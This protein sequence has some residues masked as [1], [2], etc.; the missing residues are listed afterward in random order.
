MVPLF[1]RIGASSFGGWAAAAVL[2]E[3]ELVRKRKLLSHEQMQGAVGYAQMLPGATQ[4]SL[5]AHVGYR[6]RGLR[7]AFVA[8]MSY[9]AVPMTMIAIFTVLYFRF[10]HKS[11]DLMGQLDGVIAALVGVILAN[12][13]RIGSRYASKLWL[14]SLVGVAL[15]VRLQFKIDPLVILMTYALSALLVAIVVLPMRRSRMGASVVVE[16]A[17]ATEKGTSDG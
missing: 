8:T 2:M 15:F 9:L 16:P 10:L 11:P 1:M 4:V 5:V 12:A 7:G 6:L 3:K 13:Y 14:W 17:N